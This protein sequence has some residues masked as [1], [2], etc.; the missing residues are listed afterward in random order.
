MNTKTWLAIAVV[1]PIAVVV[2]YTASR[3]LVERQ[4]ARD[5]RR[6]ALVALDHALPSD[7]ATAMVSRQ[8]ADGLTERTMMT[9]FVSAVGHWF[10]ETVY[11]KALKRQEAL[12]LPMWPI[13]P[14]SVLVKSGELT[15]GVVRLRI[16]GITPVALIFGIVGDEMIRVHCF[17]RDGNVSITSGPCDETI[18]QVFGASIDQVPN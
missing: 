7:A 16:E 14:E 18:K 6:A 9:E 10:A 12:G 5:A 3:V 11:A 17:S 4:H 15:L 8:S 1:T 13:T 2:G